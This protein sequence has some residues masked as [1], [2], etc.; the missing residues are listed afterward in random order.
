MHSGGIQQRGDQIGNVRVR[1][2]RRRSQVIQVRRL[3]IVRP[4][5]PG[6]LILIL[7]F[8][9]LIAV[10][11][12]LLMLPISSR[13]E[14]SAG[15]LRSLF[16][17]TSAVCV[18]GLAVVDTRDYW[19]PFGQVVIV[20]LIQLGGLGFMT[21]ATLLLLVF[22]R[23]V[24]L[25]H[26]MTTG[27]TTGSLGA[28]AIRTI[29]RRVILMTVGVELAGAVGLLLFFS[30][31]RQSLGVDEAWRALFTAVSAFNNAGFDIEG[32]GASLIGYQ[33]NP[34]ILG[35]VAL[36]TF[37]GSTGY[38]VWWDVFHA[39]RWDRMSLNTKIVLLTSAALIVIGAMMIFAT[40]AFAGGALSHLAKPHAA[41]S[42]LV[43]SIYSRT[44][45][46]TSFDLGQARPDTLLFIAGLMFIGGASASTAGGVKVNTFSALFFAIVASIRGDE[47]VNAFG[48]E[49]PW[50]QINRALS[51]A[52]LSV[53]IVFAS[54]FLLSFSHDADFIRILFEVVSAFATCG[55]SAALTPTLN[56]PGQLIVIVTMFVGRV[57]PLTIALALAERLGRPNRLRYP[58]AE[59]NI[60]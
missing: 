46:F 50:R 12:V 42:A 17:A 54:T 10:G 3:R 4:K 31:D 36:L 19:T 35:I 33:Q 55:L 34:F 28:S 59:L 9:A 22:G 51:V 47:H 38:A 23:R 27:E 8:L 43:E 7:G 6:V 15:L 53:A 45:G 14:G 13:P 32:G 49:I 1:R 21:S 60:G 11:T 26:R 58:E 29:I 41:F 16:T 52:L 24:S 56:E 57:G 37:I 39:K 20:A 5:H 30:I 40:E 48:R 25:G 44:S 18:T 2:G